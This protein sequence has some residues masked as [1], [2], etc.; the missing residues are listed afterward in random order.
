MGNSSA[1]PKRDRV[2]QF[3]LQQF[4]AERVAVVERD[5]EVLKCGFD[6]GQRAEAAKPS[7]QPPSKYGTEV[8]VERRSLW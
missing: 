1:S 3:V 4:A 7:D 6:L 5:V 2:Q 8:P